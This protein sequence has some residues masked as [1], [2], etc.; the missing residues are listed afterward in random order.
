MMA[1]LFF[2]VRVPETRNRELEDI[3]AD[4]GVSRRR[5]KRNSI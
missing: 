1:L 5:S 4:R 3:E 2:A